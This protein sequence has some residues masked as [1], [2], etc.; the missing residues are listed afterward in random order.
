MMECMSSCSL[1]SSSSDSSA[2]SSVSLYPRTEWVE[3]GEGNLISHN[4]REFQLCE[5]NT[6]G[7]WWEDKRRGEVG[8]EA[9]VSLTG[10]SSRLNVEM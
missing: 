5:I 4:E 7:I 10:L 9:A 2:A 1:S 3:R 6:G 8:L